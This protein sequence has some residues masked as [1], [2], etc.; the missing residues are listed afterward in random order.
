MDEENENPKNESKK[1][2]Y[3]LK[4]LIFFAFLVLL[5]VVMWENLS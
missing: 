2:S 4:R 3:F 5:Q 1:K